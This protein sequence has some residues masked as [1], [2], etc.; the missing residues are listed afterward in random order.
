MGI[1]EF[2][3]GLTRDVLIELDIVAFTYQAG[4]RPNKGCMMIHLDGRYGYI[5]LAD[6]S[7]RVFRIFDY[8]TDELLGRFSSVRD[9]INGGWKVST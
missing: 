5:T 1:S 9:L 6:A 8:E 3:A 2:D 7:S 4:D